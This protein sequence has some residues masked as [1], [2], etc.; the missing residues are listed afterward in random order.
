MIM[1]QS[2]VLVYNFDLLDSSMYIFCKLMFSLH[3]SLEAANSTSVHYI[4]LKT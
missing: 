3:C 4:Y 1:S 2:T